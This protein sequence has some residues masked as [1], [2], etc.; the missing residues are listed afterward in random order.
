[1]TKTLF[2]LAA[3]SLL[4]VVPALAGDFT[5]HGDSTVTDNVTGLMWQRTEG[6][7]KAWEDALV[8]CETLD[9]AGYD[10]WRLPNIKELESLTDDTR[11]GPAIDPLFPNVTAS[12]YWSSTSFAGGTSDAWDVYFDSGY[13]S[14]NL[15]T[16]SFFVRCVR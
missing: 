5:D 8:Y 1:M 15:K 14:H 3:L 10:D 9:L 6:G 7:Q 16:S 13:V 12:E 4:P 11:S 2:L